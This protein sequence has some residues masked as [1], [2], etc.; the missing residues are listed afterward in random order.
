MLNKQLKAI[1]NIE[2]TAEELISMKKYKAVSRLLNSS[3]ASLKS[4]NLDLF[5]LGEV[6]IFDK[7]ISVQFARIKNNL[8]QHKQSNAAKK[9]L[10]NHSSKRK[11]NGSRNRR[12]KK[13]KRKV[14]N[15]ESASSGFSSGDDVCLKNI[16]TDDFR[17]IKSDG[18]IVN[19]LNNEADEICLQ[20]YAVPTKTDG[21]SL[22][23][24][25]VDKLRFVV[26][27]IW[28]GDWMNLDAFDDIKIKRFEKEV[29]EVLPED[30]I[31][32]GYLANENKHL[33]NEAVA[34]RDLFNEKCLLN[35]QIRTHKRKEIEIKIDRDEGNLVVYEDDIK[36][37]EI[38]GVFVKSD[39]F[40]EEGPAIFDE[41]F[42]EED[43]S[44][45]NGDEE[46]ASSDNYDD[47]FNKETAYL[48]EHPDVLF[49]SKALQYK[50]LCKVCGDRFTSRTEF[51]NHT[52]MHK[53]MFLPIGGDQF[54]CKMCGSQIS[55][56]R[57]LTHYEKSHKF[58][59]V[60]EVCEDRFDSFDERI[61]H[62]KLHETLVCG[63]C[64]RTFEDSF[65]LRDHFQD[66]HA[67]RRKVKNE[68]VE[69]SNSPM[70][71]KTVKFSKT[72]NKAPICSVCGRKFTSVGRLQQHHSIVHGGMSFRK[73]KLTAEVSKSVKPIGQDDVKYEVVID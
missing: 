31:F 40:S 70:P 23:S 8:A 12:R 56:G 2:T 30:T 7:F 35:D 51:H 42:D 29:D 15:A 71:K 44:C 52:D 3:K 9:M 22:N 54:S 66:D 4:F 69:S 19:G 58:T 68:T 6:N 48:A 21:D 14:F 20:F 33:L 13:A 26:K 63:V 18:E 53:N 65:S 59:V 43:I 11:E 38:N 24:T 28:N 5:G 17:K 57:L 62:F 41:S 55:G 73:N 45:F 72:S 1:L 61:E 37:V 10:K 39:H 27:N 36:K 46:P 67:G 50:G 32:C 49:K 64:R 16:V 34:F 25:E 47:G 60:C